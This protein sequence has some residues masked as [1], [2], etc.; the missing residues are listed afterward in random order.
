VLNGLKYGAEFYAGNVATFI[1]EPFDIPKGE[2]AIS[3]TNLGCRNGYQWEGG[4]ARLGAGGEH[5]M[6]PIYVMIFRVVG[7]FLAGV[8]IAVGLL[9]YAMAGFR[10]PRRTDG[11][12]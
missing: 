10:T 9:T 7:L 5:L 11:N 6:I 1:S 12:T 8:G 2:T 3:L 4:I